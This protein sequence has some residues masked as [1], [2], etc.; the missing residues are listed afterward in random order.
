VG[1]SPVVVATTG[2]AT[3]VAQEPVAPPK[4]ASTAS[5]ATDRA[6]CTPPYTLD[7]DG[8]KRWKRACL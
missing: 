6:R 3:T 2:S 8:N 5:S 1:E 7:A 4:S